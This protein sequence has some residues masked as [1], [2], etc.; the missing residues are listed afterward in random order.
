[1]KL[2]TLT[3]KRSLTLFP[4]ILSFLLFFSLSY[5]KCTLITHTQ[6]SVNWDP[7]DQTVL[8]NEQVTHRH[9][10]PPPSSTL[11]LSPSPSHPLVSPKVDINGRS[12]RSGAIV[13]KKKMVQWFFRVS[14]FAKELN[15]VCLK[16]L[17][18]FSYPPKCSSFDKPSYFLSPPSHRILTL[19]MG[20]QTT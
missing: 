18:P 14:S 7:V 15:D 9:S 3:K 2:V 19:L 13:E 8:A 17:L 5:S 11:T 20:G 4:P 6:S 12:W 1:M 16:S 10:H